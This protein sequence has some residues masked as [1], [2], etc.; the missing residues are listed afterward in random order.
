MMPALACSV[1]SSHVQPS[2]FITATSPP[3][4]PP[5]RHDADRR[6]AVGARDRNGVALG[7]IGHARAQLR[8]EV[9]HLVDVVEAARRQARSARSC[10]RA[11]MKPDRRRAPAASTTFAPAGTGTSAP[12]ASILRAADDD[13]AA[14]DVRPGDGWIVALVIASHRR[15]RCAAPARA[16]AGAAQARP[17]PAGLRRP[18]RPFGPPARRSLPRGGSCGCAVAGRLSPLFGRGEA[19]SSPSAAGQPAPRPPSGRS[20]RRRRCR[21]DRRSRRC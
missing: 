9:E 10:V 12:S 18:R 8:V 3:K 21:R 19:S 14:L 20:R 4:M 11:L 16:A 17:S 13:R 7:V 2:R 6:D 5:R 1:A 15:R